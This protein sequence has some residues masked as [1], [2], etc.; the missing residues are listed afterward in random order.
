M[1]I[2]QKYLVRSIYLM[3]F[4]LLSNPVWAIPMAEVQYLETDLGG[5]SFQYDYF[6]TNTTDPLTDPG[7]DIF[8]VFFTFEPTV[9]LTIDSLPTDWDSNPFIGTPGFGFAV[10]FSLSPGASPVG[11]DIGPG[12]TLGGFNFVFNEQVGNIDFIA[13]FWDSIDDEFGGVFA[14][15]TAPVPEPA[16]ILLLASG[17]TGLGIFGRKRF[18]RKKI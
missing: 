9:E 8:D 12:M 2:F 10:V 6:I 4:V 15:K 1:K 11:A 5:G 3:L 7:L 16:T 13:S 17:M 14:G 18:K